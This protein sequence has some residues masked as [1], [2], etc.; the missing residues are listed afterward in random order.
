MI[1]SKIKEIIKNV[2]K[3]VCFD[4]HYVIGQL[5]SN[6]SDDYLQFVAECSKGI[7]SKSALTTETI[8]GQIGKK[9]KA[10][11]P[12]DLEHMAAKSLSLNIHNKPSQCALWRKK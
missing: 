11:S 12:D 1:D 9:L 3:G 6:A 2:P 5:I 8:H 4:T 7:F 10:L